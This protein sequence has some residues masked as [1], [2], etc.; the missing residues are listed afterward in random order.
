MFDE[1]SVFIQ[2]LQKEIM[3][4]ERMGPIRKWFYDLFNPWHFAMQ[5]SVY[6]QTLSRK[7]RGQR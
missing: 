5:L 7:T 2:L 4:M 1:E 6:K 3:R